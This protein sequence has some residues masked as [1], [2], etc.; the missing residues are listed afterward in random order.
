VHLA[1]SFAAAAIA[2]SSRSARTP[3]K[4]PS[5]TREMFFSSG[6]LTSFEKQWFGLTTRPCSI[7]GSTMSWT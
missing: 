6:M 3:R 5:R 4:L 1:R 2:S 7:P